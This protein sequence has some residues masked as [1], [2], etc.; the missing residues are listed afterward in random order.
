MLRKAHVLSSCC[1]GVGTVECAAAILEKTINQSGLLGFQVYLQNK[2]C[3]ATWVE[4][5]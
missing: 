4:W 5:V 3:F 2:K 1:T